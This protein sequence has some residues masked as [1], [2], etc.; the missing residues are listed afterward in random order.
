MMAGREGEAVTGVGS[1]QGAGS[2]PAELPGWV[3]VAALAELPPGSAREARVDGR[4][5]VLFRLDD[6]VRCLDGL[7][8][9][10]GGHLAAAS[11][12][13]E[14]VTC[15]RI[16]CLRWRFDIRTG[17]CLQHGRIRLRTYKARIQ[18]GSVFIA[19]DDSG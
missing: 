8:P 5:Y 12:A 19:T 4:L 18:A 2:A 13:H 16:G 9:H 1:S 3:R 14:V 11:P 15:P 17:A 10:Q 6:T 7:C